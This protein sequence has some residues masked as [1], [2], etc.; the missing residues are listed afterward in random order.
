MKIYCISGDKIIE[1]IENPANPTN[2]TIYI[3]WEDFENESWGNNFRITFKNSVNFND[4]I[5]FIVNAPNGGGAIAIL[6][7]YLE[8]KHPYYLV[9]KELENSPE[10]QD[11]YIVGGSNSRTIKLPSKYIKMDHIDSNMGKEQDID[12]W[13][14]EEFGKYDSTEVEKNFGE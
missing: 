7:D 10:Y 11:G 5:Y 4:D 14:E 12:E 6:V 8:K 1:D 2:N 3:N 9:P 13:Y